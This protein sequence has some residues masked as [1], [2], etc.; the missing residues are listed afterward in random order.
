[1]KKTHHGNIPIAAFINSPH[2]IYIYLFIYLFITHYS[3]YIIFLYFISALHVGNQTRCPHSCQGPGSDCL[4]PALQ[5]RLWIA[6]GRGRYGGNQLVSGHNLTIQS[7]IGV[8]L[9][10]TYSIGFF[11]PK[12]EE[13]IRA[14]QSLECFWGVSY[15][16]C[17]H[18]RSEQWTCGFVLPAKR[19][20]QKWLALVLPSKCPTQTRTHLHRSSSKM[21]SKTLVPTKP[22]TDFESPAES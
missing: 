5:E 21:S 12:K 17:C 9:L 10:S 3:F 6:T 4:S 20:T 13:T 14:A 7:G 16:C 11:P 15:S 18:A 2:Y 1:M 19:S 22:C 8:D